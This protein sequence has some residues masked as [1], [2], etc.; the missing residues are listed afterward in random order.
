MRR[1]DREVKDV[2]QIL[3]IIDEC[4]IMRLGLTDGDFPYI[5]PVNFA[6][7]LE[8][9]QIF[10]YFHGAVAGR[11]FDLLTTH[12]YCSFEMDQPV[13]LECDREKG[14]ATMRYKSVMGTAVATLLDNQKKEDAMDH[15]IMARNQETRGLKYNKAKLLETSVFELK[16]LSITAKANIKK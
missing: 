1:K 14:D 13:K 5:V 6:Y 12:P 16:V 10:L 2:K 11:K 15:F 8:N 3:E 4:Q 9:G 7:V